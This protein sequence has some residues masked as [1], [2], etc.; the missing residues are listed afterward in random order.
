MT[1]TQKPSLTRFLVGLFEA[2]I[3]LTKCAYLLA[4]ARD[5]GTDFDSE[6]QNSM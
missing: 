3:T 2:A 6:Q 1:E 4:W 5:F